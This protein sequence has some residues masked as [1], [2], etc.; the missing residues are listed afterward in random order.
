MVPRSGKGLK[1]EQQLLLLIDIQHHVFVL[2]VDCHRL[3][4][5]S[6]C[7]CGGAKRFVSNMYPSSTHGQSK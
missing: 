3:F 2:T 4:I 5:Y 6:N 7:K 1:E